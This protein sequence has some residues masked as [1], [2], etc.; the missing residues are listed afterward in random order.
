MTTDEIE[1]LPLNHFHPGTRTLSLAVGGCNLRC[2][3]CQNWQQSQTRP[4]RL[5]TWDLP[6]KRAA[7]GAREGDL[8]TIALTYTEPVAFSEYALRIAA[9]AHRK[10]VK[11]VVASGAYMNPEPMKELAKSV[12]GMCLALKGFTEDFYRDV[13]GARLKPVLDALVAAKETGVWL[14]ITTLIV[15]TLNDDMKTLRRLALWVRKN[16][17]SDTP[18]HFARFVPD[19]KL[20]NLPW[21]PVPTITRAREEALDVGLKH[22]YTT[23]V[24]PHE[25]SSTSCPSCKQ[26]LIRRVGFR[27]L[28][29]KLRDGKCCRCKKKLPGVWA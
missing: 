11:V 15:P 24:A 25:G 8:K 5:K 10:G 29:N 18:L 9:E 4:E 7:E 13:I 17:G 12:D 3:Y 28:E 14:E 22:V 19:Y 2:L 27:L 21:T 16:L 6:P 1:K 20:K 26:M 23:N